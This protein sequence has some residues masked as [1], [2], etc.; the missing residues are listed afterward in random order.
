METILNYLE[1]MF[2]NLPDNEEVR[3]AK[4]ELASMMEDKYNELLREGKSDNEAVGIV[5]SE[6]GNLSELAE[7]LGLGGI[8]SGSETGEKAEPNIAISDT[9]ARGFIEVT[10]QVA[11]RIAIGVTLC[12]YSPILLLILGGL[13]EA[14]Y[15]IS[16]VM[17][18]SVGITVLLIIVAIAVALFIVNGIKAEKYEYL[19]KREFS[20]SRR[21]E[22]EVQ[23]L[24]EETTPRFAVS[25][26]IGVVMCIISVIPLIV[27]GAVTDGTRYED[28]ACISALCLLLVIVGI[29]VQLF[30]RSGMKMDCLKILLQEGEY[31]KTMKKTGTIMDKIGSIYWPI[32]VCIYLIWSF[33]SMSWGF[34]WIIWPVA[35]ILFGVIA[36]I[37]SI[38]QSA[39][40]K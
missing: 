36:A 7:E 32:V 8:L 12:I 26:T 4:A 28:G 16:D 31:D 13:Q 23:K 14:G 30:I 11:G 9:E 37:C 3:R 34:T 19:K 1:N 39:M 15:P 33:V 21:M 24:K 2:M 40:G 10:K 27:T 22:L 17:L 5:I 6:F 38:I 29:A 18:A 25:L 20:I 35:G